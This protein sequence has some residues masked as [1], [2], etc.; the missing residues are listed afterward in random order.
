[1]WISETASLI[2]NQTS[3]TQRQITTMPSET[4]N[5]HSIEHDSLANSWQMCVLQ[6]VS[7]LIITLD[8]IKTAR[9][10]IYVMFHVHLC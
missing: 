1:M 8:R 10:A 2:Q 3:L 9:I 4:Y 6:C 5:F 7:A